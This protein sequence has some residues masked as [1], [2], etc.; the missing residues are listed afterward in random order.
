MFQV[1]NSARWWFLV[2]SWLALPVWVFL[3]FVC[4]TGSIATVSQEIIW[5]G[6]PEVRA[7]PPSG[8]ARMLSYGE[9]VAAIVRENP[10]AVVRSISRPVKSIFAWTVDTSYPDMRRVTQYVNPYT[11][12]IQGSEPHG[13]TFKQFIY[14]LHGW[15]LIP[16]GGRYNL[17][18]IGYYMVSLLSLPLLGLV[19]SGLVVYKRFW[20]GYLHPKLRFDRGFRV[21]LG[22]LHRIVGIWS[23]PFILI[24]AVTALWFLLEM[25]LHDVGLELPSTGSE[26][27][28]LV[29]REDIPVVASG[30]APPRIGFDQAAAIM[31]EYFPGVEPM[32]LRMGEN[33]F[34][35]I[36]VIGQSASWPLLNE[37]AQINPYTGLVEVAHRVTDRSSLE[38]VT[39]S[40]RPLHTGDF[41][42][43]GLKV[44]YFFFGLLLTTMVG[45]G[46]LIWTKRTV[47]ATRQ[48]VRGAALER[49]DIIGAP[50][51]EALAPPGSNKGASPRRWWWRWRFHLS[52]VVLIV[53]LTIAPFYLIGPQRVDANPGLG[54]RTVETLQVGPWTATLGEWKT[55]SP[56][57]RDGEFKKEFALSLCTSCMQEVKAAYLRVGKPRGDI[58]TSGGLFSG[59]PFRQFIAVHIPHDVRP[60]AQFWLTLEGWDGSVHRAPIPLAEASPATFQWAKGRTQ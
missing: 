12:H 53:P 37:S 34:A 39:Q 8:D 32:V 45:S 49:E 11:G 22:D 21:F 56:I 3:F 9:I 35:P 16:F 4:L 60:D 2:H 7:N 1:K 50:L 36:T 46:L 41:V 44:T 14:A 24:M 23:A 42:G 19:I 55:T 31:R 59:S 33:A 20:R 17:G 51:P 48:V 26:V 13:L 5:L 38:L 18:A 6:K 47:N 52:A 27:P 43:L 57:I 29:Q 10:D 40:M 30:R 58:R 54:Q 15:L 25:A 28:V